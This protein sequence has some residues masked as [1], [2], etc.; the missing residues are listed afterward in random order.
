MWC[1]LDFHA[2]IGS[3]TTSK[4]LDNEKDA[5]AIGYGSMLIECVLA[6][7]SLIAIGVVST[8]GAIPEGMASPTVVFA[9]AIS[10]FFATMGFGETAVT[11]TYTIIALAVSA[12]VFYIT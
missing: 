4:Q 5:L 6:V 12:F 7:V 9:T 1:C 3:G 2:L 8:N 10:N 11:A